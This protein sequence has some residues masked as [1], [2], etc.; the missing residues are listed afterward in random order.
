MLHLDSSDYYGSGAASLTLDEL[1]RWVDSQSTSTRTPYHSLSIR[2]ASSS[3]SNTLPPELQAGARHYSISLSPSL[4]LSGGLLVNHLVQSDV[5]KYGGFRLLDMIGI[6]ESSTDQNP[7]ITLRRVPSSKEDVFRDAELTLLEK[8]KLMR[9]LQFA[10]GAF[11]ESDNWQGNSRSD[12]L[13][14]PKLS[15]I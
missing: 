4:A 13:G 5:A 3:N 6:V 12:H 1:L 7:A 15:L 8:R 2:L 10:G 11:E 14:I 9:L